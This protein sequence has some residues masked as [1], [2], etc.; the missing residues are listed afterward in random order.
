MLLY[1]LDELMSAFD[2]P[3]PKSVKNGTQADEGASASPP[4]PQELDSNEGPSVPAHAPQNPDRAVE[5]PSRVSVPCPKRANGRRAMLRYRIQ[6]LEKLESLRGGYREGC[7]NHAALL[8]STCLALAGEPAL[9]VTERIKLL[10]D[11]CSR[12]CRQI[13]A[14]KLYARE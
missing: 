4:T 5:R 7:R 14:G 3:E 8:Y 11:A 9:E 12:L 13:S 2:I 1:T 10:A 6:D